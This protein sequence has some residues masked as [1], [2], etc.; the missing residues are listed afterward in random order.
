MAISNQK[1][2][3]VC[4]ISTDCIVAIAIQKFQSVR[5]LELTGMY[6]ATLL[7]IRYTRSFL[8]RITIASEIAVTCTPIPGPLNRLHDRGAVQRIMLEEYIRV[9][10][11]QKGLPSG[12]VTYKSRRR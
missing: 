3:V 6:D 4:N 7:C 1:L 9:V 11:E 12:T 10:A 2:L 8:P 5:L